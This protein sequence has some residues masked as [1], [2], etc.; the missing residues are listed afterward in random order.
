[1]T[2]NSKQKLLF[3][4]LFLTLLLSS[5]A[6]ATLIPNVQAAEAPTQ[7]KGLLILNNVVGLDLTKYAVTTKEVHVDQ[8]PYLGVLPQEDVEYD[9][10]SSENKLKAL[11]TFVDG[12]LLIIHV[13]ENNGQPNMINSE[14]SANAVE[15]AKDFLDNYQA[16]TADALYGEL[17]SSLKGVDASKN[18]TKMM[19]NTQLEVTAI[20]G[21]ATFR[22]TYAFNGVTAPSKVVALGFRNGF[23]KYFVDKWNLYS[24]GTTSIS[25]SKDEAVAIAL[26]TAKAYNWSL[27]LNADALDA[28]NFNESN[29]R[30]T[31]LLF[32]DSLGADKA[33]SED[34][35]MLYPVWRVGVALDKWYGNMYGI[36]IDIWAD[37]GEIRRVQ[38]AWSTLPPPEGVPTANM[39]SQASVSEA[40]PNLAM[41]IGLPTLAA[42]ALGVALVWMSRKKKA[43]LH[44]LLKPRSLKTGG[45]LL[46]AL[47]SSTVLLGAIATVNATT[48]AGVIWGSESSGANDPNYPPNY[49]WRKHQDEID[50][51]RE[52]AI[53]I[54]CCFANHGYT[55][56]N[57]QGNLGSTK[58][59][60]LSDISYYQSNYDYVAVVDFDH[61]LGLAPGY[62]TLL[63]PDGEFHYMFED[64]VGTITG[65]YAGP[66]E[67]HPENGVYDM[68]IHQ[69]LPSGKVIFAFINTCWS[70]KIDAGQGMLYGGGFPGRALGM[71]FAWTGRLVID[72]S[73]PGFNIAQHISIDGYG[74]P[75]LGPQVYIGFPW[76]A[77]SLMQRIPFDDGPHPYIYWVVWFFTYALGYEMSVNQ[78]LDAASL[79]TWDELFGESPLQGDGF[80][81][82]WWGVGYGP[83]STMAVYG[84]G[85]IFLGYYQPDYVSRPSVSGPTSGDTGVSYEFSASSIDPYGHNIRYTFDWGDG[86][87]QTVTGWY[88]SGDTAYASHSWSSEGI[89]SVTVRAQCDNGAWSSW[90]NPYTVQIGVIYYWLYVD[91]Y[92]DYFGGVVD[93]YVWIDGNEIG[94]APVYILVQEGWHTVTV[95][96]NW[97]YWHL[98]GFSDG[99]GNGESRPIYSD[100][101][102]TA[103]YGW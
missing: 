45:I 69:R 1:M 17:K 33:R 94:Q 40:E 88:S 15:M 82:Y 78:A 68:E 13:L 71:P 11:Y 99:Y 31:A 9:L 19:G 18:A 37:T 35:L 46:C 6:Y 67:E 80:T 29:V 28:K 64:D 85:N 53:A 23:L 98:L 87:P 66:R 60:I 95:E 41:L 21:Y 58:S 7:D 34:P 51:Q 72:K 3:I 2:K 26:E 39:S 50:S 86:S 101:D 81:A 89:F 91:A 4:T 92:C 47:I 42:V 54:R 84:N 75:D 43:H 76:G 59:Q 79:L 73:T 97:G 90:S 96:W 14:A 57:H 70:A 8:A 102:I 25:L 32:D 16:Y 49:N 36:E 61:G 20:D 93:P 24:V 65:P 30:W 63:A 38:E 62:P 12:N 5:S 44:S 55:G 74:D 77:S 48:R 52:A 22:W 10:M 56:V 100:T 27:K 103:Y 83:N